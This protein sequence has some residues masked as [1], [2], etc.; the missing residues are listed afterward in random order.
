MNTYFR[1]FAIFISLFFA[2]PAWAEC[3]VGSD[4]NMQLQVL[5]SGGPA[6]SGDRASS[7][8]LVWVDG[9]SRIMVD[10]GSGSKVPFHLSGANFND[11]DLVALSHLHPDHSA[12]LPAILWPRGGS[13]VVAGPSGDHTFPPVDLWLDRLFGENGAFKVLGDSLD[14]EPITLDVNSEEPLQVW[15][16]GDLVVRAQGVPH[17]DIPALG[18]RVDL[19]GH[20]LAFSSDQNGSDPTWVDFVK[21]VD[22][23]VVHMTTSEAQNSPLHAKPSV[24]GQMAEAA[25]AGHVVISHIGPASAQ[26][27]DQNVSVL[28]EHYSGPVTVSEDLTCIEVI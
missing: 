1:R 11:I 18:Y 7:S 28:R 25:N 2:I 5:G 23:L 10:A 15:Q 14:L 9:V 22:V 21:D 24:W 27:V 6:N 4:S 17:G 26:I 3:P 19:G 13:A 12:E 8:Y 16:D 20:S